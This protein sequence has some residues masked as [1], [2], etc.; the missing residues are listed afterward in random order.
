MFCLK[1]LNWWNAD[2]YIPAWVSVCMHAVCGSFRC[3]VFIRPLYFCSLVIHYLLVA[4]LVGCARSIVFGPRGASPL[5]PQPQPSW[6]YSA[7]L[8]FWGRHRAS[9]I[10][11]RASNF[12]LRT[13][14]F[15]AGTVKR[16][17]STVTAASDM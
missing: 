11:L 1:Q 12:E 6:S 15:D 14:N 4:S 5:A 16:R 9:S 8:L 2:L 7:I 17:P 3:G 10:E 13:S